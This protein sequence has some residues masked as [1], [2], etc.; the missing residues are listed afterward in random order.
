MVEF[1]TVIILTNIHRFYSN[2][3]WSKKYYVV[4]ECPDSELKITGFLHLLRTEWQT[5]FHRIT[6]NHR[7]V[8]VGRD[9]CGSSSKSYP[10]LSFKLER[11]RS[12][13]KNLLTSAVTIS[14]ICSRKLL[15][16]WV[17][18]S[19]GDVICAITAAASA[20][21]ASEWVLSVRMSARHSIPS[22]YGKQ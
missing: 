2:I 16:C 11:L 10:N 22:A 3:D 6:Q 19:C 1:H 14:S 7:M 21:V 5:L 8:G 4:A 13:I 9:L 18:V 20:W 15:R 17:N 12:P